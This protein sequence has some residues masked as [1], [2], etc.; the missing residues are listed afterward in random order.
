MWDAGQMKTAVVAI[1]FL[2]V[3]GCST[4]EQRRHEALMNQIEKQV[5]LPKGARP[6]SG[7]ARYYAYGEGGQ[8]VG[9]Y[10]VPQDDDV[11]PGET[12]EQ[13]FENLKTREVPCPVT[14]HAPDEISAGRRRWLRDF[15]G[16]PG[17]SDGGCIAVNLVFDPTTAT[18]KEIACNGLA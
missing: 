4:P 13:V 3:A 17:I 7:Y 18:V 5:Q 8:I 14:E 15:N 2:L 11:R 16:L 9:F 1:A 6:L 10:M 12:C